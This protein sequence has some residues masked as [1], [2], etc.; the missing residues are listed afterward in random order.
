[1]SKFSMTTAN[2]PTSQL[3]F[4]LWPQHNTAFTSGISLWSKLTP[5]ILPLAYQNATTPKPEHSLKIFLPT[6]KPTRSVFKVLLCIGVG[7]LATCTWSQV[8]RPIATTT[9]FLTHTLNYTTS[10]TTTNKVLH[11]LPFK[12]QQVPKPTSF[13]IAISTAGSTKCRSQV[14]AFYT[15]KPASTKVSCKM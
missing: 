2:K 12:P 14:W 5:L 13:T 4:G 1:M 7:L 11:C 6:P 3:P 10:A 8:A 15:E 9:A